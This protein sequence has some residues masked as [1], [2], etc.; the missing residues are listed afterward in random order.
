M[1]YFFKYC[2]ENKN[3]FLEIIIKNFIIVYKIFVGEY[4]I[5]MIEDNNKLIIKFYIYFILFRLFII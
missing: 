3:S 1:S 2:F 4:I 5:Y